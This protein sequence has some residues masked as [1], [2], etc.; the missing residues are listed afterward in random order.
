MWAV[1]TP[2]SSSRTSPRSCFRRGVDSRIVSAVPQSIHAPLDEIDRLYDLQQRNRTAVASTTAAQRIAKLR[3]FERALLSRA[4]E[5][6]TA[7]WED[8]R[9]PAS[10]V[11]LSEIYPVV[12]EARHAIRHLRRWMKPRRVSNRL[13]LFGGRSTIVY[14]PKGV[15]LI[16]APW[17]FPF[18]LTLGPLVSAIAAGNCAIAK[19]SELTP[20]S[21]ACMKRIVGDLFEESEVAFVE[22]DATVAEA[23]LKKKFDH[24]F[25]TGSP[26]V[27]RVVMKAAAEHL[28]SVTLELGGKSPVI[29]DKT[30][31]VD[32]AAKKVAWGKFYNCGQVCIAPDYVLVEESIRDEFVRKLGAAITSLG[33]EGSRGTIVNDR[34]A[35]RVKRLIDSAVAQGATVAYGGASRGREIEPTVLTN[36]SEGAAVMEEEIFGPVLPVLPYRTLDEALETI[37]SKEKPLVLYIFSRARRV[38]REILARTRAGGTVVNHTL[39]HFYQLELPFGGVGHSGVGKSHGFW[40]FESFSNPRG[41]FDQRLPF[42][43]TEMLFPPYVGRLKKSKRVHHILRALALVT[44]KI[45]DAKLYVVGEGDEKYKNYLK[46]LVKRNNLKN[47]VKFTGYIDFIE[48]NK[49]MSRAEAI[50]V[51]SVKEGWGLIATEANAL[52]TAA[53]V[54]DVDGLRDSV[55]NNVTGLVV[56]PDPDHL[57]EAIVGYLQDNELK[58]RLSKNALE[59]SRRFDWDKSA[60]ESLRSLQAIS[61]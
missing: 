46:K 16:I 10:E 12:S 42:S 49:L 47:N 11:D 32:E 20:A 23:L 60:M 28:T 58:R 59:D 30:A 36:V 18:N 57:S 41:V 24:I 26:S 39:V 5:I 15:V 21:A 14:E 54:Y 35:A 34:H 56:E 33:S 1:S 50:I 25:F 44:K 27:G 7:M 55:R 37:A 2:S 13:A 61:G 9:K 8:Y 6:R 29:V 38:V 52:G 53:I 40:G 22:G 48:R 43:P 3:R 45:P 17:N 51:A 31:N 4:D 19:P